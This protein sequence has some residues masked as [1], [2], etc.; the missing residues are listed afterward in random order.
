MLIDSHCHLDMLEEKES[1]DEVVKRALL[2]NVKFMQTICTRL[3]KLPEIIKIAEKYD[4]VF[5]SVGLHPNEVE[6]ITLSKDLIELASHPKIIGF[7]ETGL[8]YYYS[9]S[10]KDIQIASLIEHIV[11][12]QQ[13]KL[14]III[15]TR[16]ADEDTIDIL[17][18]EMANSHYTGLI[19]CF[20]SS[21][22]LAQKMLDIG[23]YISVSGI[24]TFKNADSLREII[25]FIPLDRLLIETDSPYLAPVPFRG[26]QN[27]PA[28]VKYVADEIAVIKGISGEEVAK[29]TSENFFHLFSKAK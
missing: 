28:F 22:H 3:D 26:K 21:K 19:H 18:K 25:K 13:A 4:N 7:G 2:N 23:I 15:H 10:K 1:L 6:E 5:A 12:A 20:T 29:V 11:A 16:D 17:T 9:I 24:I 8:D 27:E 14:P